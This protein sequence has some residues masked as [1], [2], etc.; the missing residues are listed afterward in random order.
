MFIN[1]IT[2]FISVVN[3]PVTFFVFYEH[4]RVK[5]THFSK[6]WAKI[7]LESINKPAVI[8]ELVDLL[9]RVYGLEYKGKILDAIL[10]R[11]EMMSTGVGYGIAIPHAKMDEISSPKLVGGI[12]PAGIDFGAVDGRPSTIFFLL[13]SPRNGSG[14]HVRI[15]SGLSRILHDPEVREEA[16]SANTQEEFID[17]L[18]EHDK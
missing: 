9:C 14:D 1:A 8:A 6:N 18:K 7:P 15:L 17:V 11:E 12:A 4:S 13:V 2:A 10:E 5:I 3:A 16:L